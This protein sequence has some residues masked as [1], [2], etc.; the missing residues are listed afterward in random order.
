[1]LLHLLSGSRRV[2]SERR[3][4]DSG[5]DVVAAEAVVGAAVFAALK[6][7]GDAYEL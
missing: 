3:N 7:V 5:Q 6:R 2:L 1:M 4:R